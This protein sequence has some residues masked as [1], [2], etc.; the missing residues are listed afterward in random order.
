MSR[1]FQR[2]TFDHRLR[3][4]A[5]VDML[6]LAADRQPARDAAY[7]E[8]AREQQLAD[9]MRGRLALDRE[10]R[11]HDNLVHLAVI[12]ALKQAIE[13][14]VLGSDAVERG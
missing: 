12:G 3:E 10:I 5:A 7:L 11:R 9:I 8:P 2:A 4:R 13:M 14:N 1:R 6:E